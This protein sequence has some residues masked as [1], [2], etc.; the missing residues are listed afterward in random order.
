[1]IKRL[2]VALAATLAVQL[3]WAAGDARPPAEF[4]AK[5]Q[6]AQAQGQAAQVKGQ[7]LEVK[8]VDAY[9]YLRLKTANGETWAAVN[10]AQVKKGAEV[11]I[12]NPMVMRN[13]ESRSL[14]RTF[15]T[16][17]FGSLA[18]SAG[19]AAAPMGSAA[20]ASGA[21]PAN[22]HGAPLKT[23]EVSAAGAVKVPKAEGVNGRTVAEVNSDRVKL[24]D[25]AV[26]IRATVVKVTANVMGKNWIHLRDGSGSEA[27]KNNDVLVTSKD[28]PKVGDVVVAKGVVRT[29]VD[30]G[31]GY[32]YKVLVEDVSFQK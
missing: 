17:V 1:M 5:V 24:K 20:P 8:D 26:A 6:L 2:L 15:D 12:E 7:V 18:G 25:K 4:G 19:T 10:R 27:D 32:A 31:A 3:A 29:D 16:I 28:R 30:L 23:A 9:T 14:N 11:T 22:P 13:F 21:D